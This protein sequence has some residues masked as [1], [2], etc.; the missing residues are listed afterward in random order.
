MCC[1]LKK[2]IWLHT[3]IFNLL[4]HNNSTAKFVT[5]GTLYCQLE[6]P[7]ITIELTSL[8]SVSLLAIYNYIKVQGNFR[9]RR[10]KGPE[11]NAYLST[12]NPIVKA[13]MSG[14]RFYEDCIQ[15][16]HCANFGHHNT[17]FAEL[18]NQCSDSKSQIETK[19][20]IRDLNN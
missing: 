7:S 6:L 13:E 15:I 11:G 10:K 20:S 12:R 16:S 14:G 3:V 4:I 18:Q 17:P 19:K 1:F 5:E 9:F 8:F 2:E